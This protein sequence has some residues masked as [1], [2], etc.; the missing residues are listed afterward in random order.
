MCTQMM[1]SI[2]NCA[3]FKIFEKKDPKLLLCNIVAS[4]PMNL[5][6]IDLVGLETMMDT[7][8][9]PEVQK[10]LLVVDHFSRYVQAYKVDNK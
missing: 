6:H 8:K 2:L 7:S 3:K 1:R 4:E 5:I 10:L 9:K